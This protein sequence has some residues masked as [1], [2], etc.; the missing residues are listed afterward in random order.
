M[1][2]TMAAFSRAMHSILM[3]LPEKGRCLNAR[4]KPLVELER[5]GIHSEG[6]FERSRQRKLSKYLTVEHT[7]EQGAALS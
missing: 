2:T 5:A 3:H 6:R 4:G 7:L 1:W